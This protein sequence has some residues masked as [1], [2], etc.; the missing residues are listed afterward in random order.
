LRIIPHLQTKQH[1]YLMKKTTSLIAAL[2]LGAAT[3]FAGTHPA[4][5]SSGKNPPPPPPADPCA[6]PISYNNIELLYA[7]TDFDHAN[8]DGNG[9]QLNLEYA[10]TSNF[11]LTAG[12]EYST[13]DDVD[14]WLVHLGIGGYF[15]LTPNI[16]LAVD[17]GALWSDIS[18]DNNGPVVNPLGN[19]NGDGD[20]NEWG[21]Y[22]RPHLR[23]KWGCLTVHLGAEYRDIFRGDWAGYGKLY[24][25]INPAWDLTAGVRFSEDETQ[26]TAGVRF[27]Y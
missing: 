1:Q 10:P 11:F 20:G 3:A 19:G 25:Q 2:T 21:W 4:P 18:I 17:G 15:A 14:L 12:A 7:W 22:I 26:V 5:M 13:G 24:Y 16:H 6:G 27:R 23:A 8:N 9:F